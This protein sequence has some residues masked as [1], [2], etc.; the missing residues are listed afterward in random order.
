MRQSNAVGGLWLRE[1]AES[2]TTAGAR[3]HGGGL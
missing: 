2:E 1:P 3:D